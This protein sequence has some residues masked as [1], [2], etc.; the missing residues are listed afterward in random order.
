LKNSDQFVSLS[1]VRKDILNFAEKQWLINQWEIA[2]WPDIKQHRDLENDFCHSYLASFSING[3]NVYGLISF[4]KNTPFI[5]IPLV[6]NLPKMADSN[7]IYH[8]FSVLNQKVFPFTPSVPKEEMEAEAERIQQFFKLP[9]S[10]GGFKFEFVVGIMGDKK[11]MLEEVYI[12]G[13][14][15]IGGKPSLQPG[16]TSEHALN[17]IQRLQ[18]N[19]GINAM[20]ISAESW[21]EEAITG[22]QSDSVIKTNAQRG[23]D[24]F[25][26][27]IVVLPPGTTEQVAR[28]INAH[29]LIPI[30]PSHESDAPEVEKMIKR[31]LS[32]IRP[33]LRKNIIT[34]PNLTKQIYNTC[35]RIKNDSSSTP[36][37]NSVAIWLQTNIPLLIE[38]FLFGD[39]EFKSEMMICVRFSVALAEL[40]KKI[41]KN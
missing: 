25:R 29:G 15:D 33:T 8:N 3:I 22:I 17:Y 4:F 16:I 40:Q 38:P 12:D 28:S 19:T 35:E 41:V 32:E 24:Q 21:M 13:I 27:T 1:P 20:P 36:V 26:R 5:T 7:R 6:H 2:Y 37:G 11:L 31:F 14:G 39:N 10:H 30:V 18:T 23:T 9:K 34:V